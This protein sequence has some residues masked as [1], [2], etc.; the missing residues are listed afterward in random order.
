MSGA[1]NGAGRGWRRMSRRRAWALAAAGVLAVQG[2]FAWRGLT[3]ARLVVYN[4]G[5]EAVE[6]AAWETAGWRAEL[7]E[8]GAETS[9]QAWAEGRAEGEGRMLVVLRWQAG[10]AGREAGWEVEPGER[11]TVRLEF[12]EVVSAGRERGLARRAADWVAEWTGE[13]SEE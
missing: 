3:R 4:E 12:G 1:E 6:A 7:G 5:P 11:L 8:M 10:G 2:F 9:R 13:V